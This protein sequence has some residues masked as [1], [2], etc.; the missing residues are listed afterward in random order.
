MQCFKVFW[1]V[2]EEIEEVDQV[3]KYINEPIA[4]M[5]N[6]GWRIVNVQSNIS[7]P[8]SGGNGYPPYLAVS[9]LFEN[10]K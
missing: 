9:V 10:D 1:T 7:N 8:G 4:E 6:D 5:L 2:P 3:D